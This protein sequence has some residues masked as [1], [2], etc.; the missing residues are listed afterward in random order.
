MGAKFGF[1]EVMK[2]PVSKRKA[3]AP[4]LPCEGPLRRWPSAG[5]KG[6]LSQ[7][8]SLPALSSWTSQTPRIVRNKLQLFHLPRV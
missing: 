5:K 2:V 7:A 1:G 4:C 6:A 8:V 3:K